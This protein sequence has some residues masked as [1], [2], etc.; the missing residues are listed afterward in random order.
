MSQIT[1]HILDTSLGR[2]AA[3]V[4]V[5]LQKETETG[6]QT[7]AEGITN[8]DGRVGGL[9]LPEALHAAIQGQR[10]AGPGPPG[11]DLVTGH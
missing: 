3:G 4:Q 9:H 2:P 5:L 6:W 11:P 1:T 8:Q 7:I 10:P